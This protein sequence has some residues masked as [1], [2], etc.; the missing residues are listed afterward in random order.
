MIRKNEWITKL[1]LENFRSKVL[2]K[3]KG[4]EVNNND[5]A[6]ERFYQDEENIHK[7]E[8]TQ[9]NTENLGEEEKTMIQDIL[10]LMNDN[11]RIEL[12][13][14]NKI[15]RSLLA[16][17]SRKINCILKHITTENITDTNILIKAVIVYEG[18]KIGL[19]ACGSK[20]K[21]NRNPGGKEG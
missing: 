18:K 6:G 10:D 1:E 17:W 16:E 5:N 19:K 20:N 14:F 8:A 3:E 21:M 2:Q 9:V 13:G 7:N 11:S 12:R 4:I 15:D